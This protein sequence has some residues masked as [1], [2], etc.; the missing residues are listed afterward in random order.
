MLLQF[1][2]S[3]TTITMKYNNEK[4]LKLVEK[5]LNWKKQGKEIFCEDPKPV[6]E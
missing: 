2:E 3:Q 4:H 6:S 5:F 1:K